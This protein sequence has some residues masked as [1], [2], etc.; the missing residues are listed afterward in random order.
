MSYSQGKSSSSGTSTTS[1]T[2]S[3]Q[4]SQ[5]IGNQLQTATG[6]QNAIGQNVQANSDLYNQGAAGVN[7]AANNLAQTGNSIS[8][9]MGQGGAQGY[10]T[11]MNALQ[12]LTGADYQQQQMSAAMAPAQLAY[13]QN[14]AN[15]NSQ[16]G[17]AGGLGSARAAL[18]GGQLAGQESS[19]MAQAGAQMQNQLAQQ[20]LQ[21]AQGLTGAGVQGGQLGLQGAQAGV[22]ASQVPQQYLQ[23][24]EQLDAMMAGLSQGQPNFAGTQGMTQSTGQQGNTT[25][26]GVQL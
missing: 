3:P 4:Q 14:M 1:P 12:N 2:I 7:Q 10:Q 22:T 24:K 15:M 8:Q 23:S 21:A 16:Q 11:G 13:Q 19:Q 6:L 9:N 18:A 26:A 25:N 5:Y 17:A 20:K